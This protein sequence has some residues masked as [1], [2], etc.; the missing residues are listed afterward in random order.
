MVTAND[1][2]GILVDLTVC[3]NEMKIPLRAMNA[4]TT[5]DALCLI[6]L[7]LE[8]KSSDQLSRA[9]SKV[10]TIKDVLSVTRTNKKL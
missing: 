8:I 4:K 10:E 5:K 7:T 3:F 2:A 9:I 6:T 1:R